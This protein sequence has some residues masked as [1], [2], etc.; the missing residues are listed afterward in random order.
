MNTKMWC[1]VGMIVVAVLGY[2][3]TRGREGASKTV[4]IILHTVVFIFF[5]LGAIILHNQ[6]M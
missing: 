1:I 6:G 2:L 5:M 3:R 4:T